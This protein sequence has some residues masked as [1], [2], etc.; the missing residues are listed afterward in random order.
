MKQPNWD[1]ITAV[2]TVLMAITG[3]VAVVFAVV[4]IKEFREE[5]RVQHLEDRIREYDSPR[6]L[7]IR[8]SLADQRIDQAQKRLRKLDPD[9]EP[10]ELDEELDFCNDLGL[11]V[12]KGALDR[13]DV[14]SV[15]S[16]WLFDL[17]ADARP[18]IDSARKDGPAYF[19]ECTDL[20]KSMEPIEEEENNGS[21][22]HPSEDDRYQFYL[23]ELNAQPGQQIKGKHATH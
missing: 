22:D 19:G 10:D 12:S 17:Y 5:A 14:W 2:S 3:I 11:L 4:Q 9:N 21:D 6:F 20:V 15:F 16:T 7:A 23:T 13:N 18:V 1:A 8:K